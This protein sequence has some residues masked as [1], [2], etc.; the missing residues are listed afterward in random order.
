[1][2]ISSKAHLS[3]VDSDLR[4]GRSLSNIFAAD[5][6][7]EPHS[8][9]YIKRE[10]FK[11]TKSQPSSFAHRQKTE[12]VVNCTGDIKEFNYLGEEET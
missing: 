7:K 11:N 9:D 8:A 6:D 3:R 1:M 4:I 2:Q 10:N 5:Y 12:K